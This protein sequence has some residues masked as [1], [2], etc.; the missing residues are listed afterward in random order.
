[1]G[2]EAKMNSRLHPDYPF[3]KSEILY[4]IKHEMAEKPND[5]LCRR[6]PISFLHEEATATL[7]PEVVDMLAKEKK[8]SKDRA[9]K[10]LEEAKNNL[11][12]MK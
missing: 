1:M 3:L 6:V 2:H 7:L 12:F 4:A 8:W 11:K 5:I 10:E 9:A